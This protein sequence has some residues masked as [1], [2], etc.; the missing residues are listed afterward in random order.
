MSTGGKLNLELANELL[1]RI[2]AAIAL[3]RLE[4]PDDPL[5]LRYLYANRAAGEVTGTDPQK[6]VGLRFADMDLSDEVRAR[7]RLYAQVALTGQLVALPEFHRQGDVLSQ[8]G[9]Y[10]VRLIPLPDRCVA[11]LALN[12]TERKAAERT[13]GEQERFLDA[14]LENLP[15]MVFVKDAKELRFVRFNRAGELL[16]GYPREALI[17][18]NDFDLF[19]K[20]QAEFFSANDRD[21]LAS[22]VLRDIA[23][24]PIDTAAGRRWLHTKKVP[25]LDD[26]G[27]PQ[28]LLGISEDITATRAQQAEVF[29][30][31]QVAEEVSAA[32]SHF[33]A[34]V[35]HEIRTPL[36]A[37]LGLTDLLLESNLNPEQ[38]EHL[39]AAH[40]AAGALRGLLN[41]ILDYEKGA[42]G[43]M[44]LRPE[45][46]GPREHL[47][48]VLRAFRATAGAKGVQLLAL[49]NDDVPQRLNADPLRLRQV[50]VNLVGNAVKFTQRGQVLVKLSVQAPASGSTQFLR[51]DVA[52]T[53]PGIRPDRH[54][55]V[56]DAFLQ[57]GDAGHAAGGSGLG[58]AIARQLV[59]LM[60][61]RIGLDSDEGKGATFWFTVACDTPGGDGP[62][63]PAQEASLTLPAG[64][65][66]LVVEDNA[67]NVLLMTRT[68][69][70]SG[71]QVT[72]AHNGIEALRV[73]EAGRFDVVFMDVQMPELDGLEATRR[74]RQRERDR[75]IP[76]LPVIALT[77]HNMPGDRERCL[78][79]GADG[80]LS[81]PID[82]RTVV[83]AIIDAIHARSPA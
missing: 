56:F 23:E 42:A 58:L 67:V 38:R 22:G 72:V 9:W 5:S 7:A 77:A 8:A 61:G 52:D 11:F 59:E 14:I 35:S 55:D 24:E 80:Y 40:S 4:D 15:N 25:V 57:V 17:G 75:G 53:G 13:V 71:C 49:V 43:R 36:N 45:S 70:R 69:E 48:D 78:A 50:L 44:E 18:K 32:K 31:K 73:I 27:V 64:M 82:R 39:L 10:S 12:I 19:P 83:R 54:A 65:R 76:H 74:L 34:R 60:G 37:I 62:S 30:L 47:D 1:D 21:V 20:V 28:Y 16:L 63:S 68:L 29:R 2:P 26:R 33:M 51:Y 6:V 3:F 79:A 41:D 66:V 81:K 46:I